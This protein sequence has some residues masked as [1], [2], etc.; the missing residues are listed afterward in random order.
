MEKKVC[1]E[2]QEPIKGRIDKKFCSDYCRNT[3]NN[4]VAK[5]SKNLVR[6]INNRLKKNYKIL[7]ELND[8]GKTRVSR[9]KLYDK[10]FDFQL[11]T[12]IYQTK[13]GNTYFYVYDEGYLALEN[14]WFLLIKKEI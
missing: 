2:C 8:S 10:G 4:S 3:Y 13:T 12:S 14:D 7:S 11:F 6:N 1:L 5:D 9:T